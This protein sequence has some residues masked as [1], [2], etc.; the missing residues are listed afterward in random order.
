[1]NMNSTRALFLGRFQPYHNGHDS[2]IRKIAAEVDELIIAI[3]SAQYSHTLRDPFTAG[4][5]ITMITRALE[6]TQMTK[7]VLPVEDIEQNALYVAHIRRLTPAFNVVYSNNSL[8]IRLFEEAGITVKQLPLVDRR[9]LWGTKIRE[10]MLTDGDWEN[11]V[12]PA[13]SNLVGEVSGIDRIQKINQTD[14]FEVETQNDGEAQ[15]RGES[16]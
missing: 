8:V 3:G 10:W 5:R 12:P 9:A 15:E 6:D 7:Y 2:V 4:E 16:D 1:M 14:H 13:V 11:F